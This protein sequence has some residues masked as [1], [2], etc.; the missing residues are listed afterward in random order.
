LAIAIDGKICEVDALAAFA[1]EDGPAVKVR[2]GVQNIVAVAD[3]GNV[4][5]AI[6]ELQFRRNL[7][8]A[9]GQMNHACVRQ[10]HQ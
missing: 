3:D 6:W 10:H 9:R 8:D 4:V 2:R 7:G 5:R 1:T